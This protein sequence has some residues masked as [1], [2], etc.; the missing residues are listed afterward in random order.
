MTPFFSVIIPLYN[1]ENYIKA[2][3][4]SVLSQSFTDFEVIVVNDGST[5]Q[6]L[7]KIS[8][9]NDS[10]IK[11]IN[12]K[13]LGVSE[14]RNNGIA[15]AKSE[16]IALIDADDYW[17]DNHLIELKKQIDLFP[18]AGLYCNNYE[19]FYNSTN[20]RPAHINLDY[21]EDCLLV[22]DFF[23]ASIVNP[24]AWTSAVGFS[25][26]LFNAIGKFNT[27]LKTAQD[28][29]LWMRFA[30]QYKVAFNPKITMAYKIHVEDSLSKKEYNTIRY[31]FISKYKQEELTNSSLKLYLDKNRYAVALRCKINNEK[32]LYKK[33]KEEID[34]KNLNLKQKI[35][36]NCSKAVLIVIKQFQKS[37]LKNNIYL[38]AYK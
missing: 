26:A 5:D 32:A 27:H 24:V 25:K 31:Q 11:I 12:Q 30:L 22:A 21:N 36:L 8:H 9:F 19:V 1:K 13:N 7:S 16:Y 4:E 28:L 37:L 6:G 38:T 2:T 23:K 29:D 34:Y 3:L 18:E 35:L 14:A 33:L 17:Y 20:S 15:N 10:R